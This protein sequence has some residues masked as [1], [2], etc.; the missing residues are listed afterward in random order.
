MEIIITTISV[1]LFFALIM[2]IYNVLNDLDIKNRIIICCMEI[3]VCLIL[4]IIIF[5]L[6]S[7]GV[8]YPNNKD[9]MIAMKTLV[10]I[11][12]PINGIIL[13]PNITKTIKQSRHNEISKNEFAKKIK[14]ITII[15]IILIII[16]IIYLKN[17]QQGILNY[18]KIQK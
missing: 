2:I 7:V 16:E 15:F 12:A 14:K 9:K 6:A 18:Y 3:I 1:S 11:F 5:N 4:T 17:T 10:S 8:E 13:M